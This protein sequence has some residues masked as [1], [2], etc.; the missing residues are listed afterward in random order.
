M[1]PNRQNN[2][3]SYLI[4]VGRSHIDPCRMLLHTLLQKTEAKIVL[5]G[6]LSTDEADMFKQYGVTYIDENEIDMTGR[7]PAVDWSEKYRSFGWYKQQF[8]RLCIDRFMD[9]DQVVILDSEVFVFEN[10]DE[11]RLYDPQ[12]GA[13][14][15]FYWIP[16]VRK[17]DWDYKMYRGSAYLLS[18]LPECEGIMEYANS[19]EYKRHIYG[20]GLFSTKN[21][22]S[23]WERLQK[24]TDLQKNMDMLFNHE[25]DLSFSEYEFYGQAVEYGLFDDV[26]PTVMCNDLQGWYEG[27]D[28]VNFHVFMFD[29]ILCLLIVLDYLWI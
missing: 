18:F 25:P 1:N 19:T 3:L 29:I 21:I 2:T 13:P 15:S 22:A 23:L 7:L 10:W 24:N 26:V 4:T 12:S 14:R 8:I 9:T 6:N 5:V 16:R 27:H 11:S 17:P 20:V 28:D